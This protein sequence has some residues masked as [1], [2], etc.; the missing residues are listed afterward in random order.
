MTNGQIIDVW[1]AFECDDDRG[2]NGAFIGIFRTQQAAKT[3][4]AGRGFYGSEGNVEQRKAA[5]FADDVLYLLDRTAPMALVLGIDLIK[6]KEKRIKQAM[7]KL[8]DEE[9]ELLGLK[10]K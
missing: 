10:R 1:A 3:A 5:Y 9:V 6:T 7:D 8:T 2:R 4:A